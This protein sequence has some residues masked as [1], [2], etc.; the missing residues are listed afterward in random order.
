MKR[1]A[2]LSPAFVLDEDLLALAIREVFDATD[3]EDID[4]AATGKQMLAVAEAYARR[5][6]E[7]YG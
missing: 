4:T 1:F 6:K 2:N 7:H 3:D 5:M